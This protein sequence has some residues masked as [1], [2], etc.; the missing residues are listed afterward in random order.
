[1]ANDAV[2]GGLDSEYRVLVEAYEA[3]QRWAATL[4][5][6]PEEVERLAV[7]CEQHG[8]EFESVA[9]GYVVG[10]HVGERSSQWADAVALLDC[11]VAARHGVALLQSAWSPRQDDGVVALDPDRVGA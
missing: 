9:L 5:V 11:F 8:L 10:V 1:M 2:G 4:G 6:S 7:L 3:C